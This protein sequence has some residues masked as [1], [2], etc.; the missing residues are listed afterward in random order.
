MSDRRPVWLTDDEHAELVSLVRK[1]HLPGHQLGRALRVM[2]DASPEPWL[3]V[4]DTGQPV[5]MVPVGV[6]DP[7]TEDAVLDVDPR[8]KDGA[9]LYRA[10]PVEDVGGS[11]T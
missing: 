5:R 7:C 1:H 11:S 3:T 6:I 2:L 10:V 9:A 8:D 4:N